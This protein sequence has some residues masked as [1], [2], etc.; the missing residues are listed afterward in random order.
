MD[1]KERR[2]SGW[3]YLFFVILVKGTTDRIVAIIKYSNLI[4]RA[5]FF[6]LAIPFL[7]GVGVGNIGTADP[8]C[9]NV[10]LKPGVVFPG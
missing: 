10:H 6:R 4:Q 5:A 3:R 8:P 7:C 2:C 1:G 9:H